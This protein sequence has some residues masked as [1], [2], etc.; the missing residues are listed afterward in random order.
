MGLATL[1]YLGLGANLG[2]PIQQLIDARRAIFDWHLSANGRSSYFYT[3]SPVGDTQQNE[4]I[5]CALAIQVDASPHA[6][7]AFCQTLELRLG[8]QRD[9]NNRNAARSIDIDILAIP[10][11][12]VNEAT[13]QIPHPRMNE[14]LFVLLPLLEVAE[15]PYAKSLRYCIETGDFSGQAIHRLAV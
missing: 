14:R 8:R 11:L 12:S 1:A 3:S 15:E 4:Y 9:S 10:G 13:L 6:L 7:L 2:D 5:N